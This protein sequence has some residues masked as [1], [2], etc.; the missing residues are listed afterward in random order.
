MG[1]SK[2]WLGK[3]SSCGRSING[4]SL[5]YSR[6]LRE[7]IDQIWGFNGMDINFCVHCTPLGNGN[8]IIITITTI[9]IQFKKR[10]GYELVFK[11]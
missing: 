3:K 9:I 2:L 10:E 6:L 4:Y 11:F 7:I 1:R 5:S 8:V